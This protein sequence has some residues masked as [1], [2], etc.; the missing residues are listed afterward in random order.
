MSGWEEVFL[1][2][3]NLA[4]I[5][6]AIVAGI[7][8]R[9]FRLF[10]YA[11]VVLASGSYHLCDSYSVCLFDY[12]IHHH[13]D[14]TFAMLAVPLTA[15]YFPYWRDRPDPFARGIGYPWLEKLFILF[16]VTLTAIL[17]TTTGGSV[18]A[19]GI[20]F[21]L[22]L[23]III[24]YWIGY[25]YLYLSIPRYEWKSLFAGSML[26]LISV[27]LFLI[28]SEAPEAYWASHS[29]WHILGAFGQGYILMIKP[30]APYYLNAESKMDGLSIVKG[31]ELSK[32]EKGMVSLRKRGNNKSVWQA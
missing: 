20:L 25:Y 29:L 28:Q 17:V 23:V 15:L 14:F 11:A 6:P 18:T 21:G 2:I 3:S 1:T 4:F 8:G 22:S 31:S 26:T 12:D 16:F 10:I 7:Y 19:Q 27:L 32:A 24:G 5:A 9:F 30:P 13:L